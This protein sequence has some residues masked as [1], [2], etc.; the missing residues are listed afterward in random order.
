MM[1]DDERSR[2]IKGL[3]RRIGDL[4]TTE[5]KSEDLIAEELEG[6]PELF[7]LDARHAEDLIQ[8]ALICGRIPVAEGYALIRN[9]H[10]L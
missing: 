8:E 10:S 3:R 9:R 5:Y 2:R 6:C 1:G 7:G 4:L